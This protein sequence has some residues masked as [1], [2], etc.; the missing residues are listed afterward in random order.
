MVFKKTKGIGAGNQGVFAVI[1]TGG[2]QYK[3]SVGDTVK[4]EKLPGE[5]KIGGKVVF[6]KVLLTESGSSTD[7][8]APFVSGAKV[9][10]VLKEEGRGKKIEVMK[11]KAKSRYMKIRGHRQP[12]MEV[13][14]ISIK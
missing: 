1:S 13:E 8:G 14:I 5:N 12:Y 2:K 4:I 11:Y 7:V 6:D 10:A 3:V 9:E